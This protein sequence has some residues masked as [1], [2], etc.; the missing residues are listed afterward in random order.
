M[1]CTHIMSE[2]ERLCDL[3]YVLHDGVIKG[4]GS[5]DEIMELAGQPTLERAFLMLAGVWDVER[6]EA[7]TTSLEH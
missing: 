1:Y 5:V 4:V 3:V 2:V 6:N 7:I